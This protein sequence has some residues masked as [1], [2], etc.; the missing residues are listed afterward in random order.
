MSRAAGGAGGGVKGGVVVRSVARPAKCFF[1]FF[2]AGL[3]SV[4]FQE[5]Y[6]LCGCDSE[7]ADCGP[8][9]P[10]VVGSN[11]PL[12]AALAVGPPAL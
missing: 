11:G 10:A 8:A 4:L 9:G 7:R 2:F 3:P 5:R 6:F 12:A 1:W